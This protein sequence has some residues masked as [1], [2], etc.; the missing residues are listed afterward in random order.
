MEEEY[1]II[2][3]HIEKIIPGFENFNQRVA[4]GKEFYL[5]NNAREL[6]F[7]EIGGKAK[8]T[9]HGLS[10]KEAGEKSL[11]LMTIRSHDQYNTTIYGLDDR[12]RGRKKR[13]R[14]VFLNE[15][16]MRELGIEKEQPVDLTSHFRGRKKDRAPLSCPALR[17][18]EGP[19]AY[20]PE[21]NVLVPIDSTAKV[22]QTPTSK[23]NRNHNQTRPNLGLRSKLGETVDYAVEGTV[24]K[25]NDQSRSIV[26][27]SFQKIGKFAV[28]AKGPTLFAPLLDPFDHG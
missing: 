24:G 20:F 17:H 21:T 8:F 14:V 15:E 2:R 5:P 1:A 16:D 26:E 12:Y 23:A 9:V 7:S 3:N 13:R 27:L 11:L 19:A 28:L 4:G 22:S 10:A 6:D 25:E 18:T